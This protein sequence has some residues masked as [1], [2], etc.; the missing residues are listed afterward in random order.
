MDTEKRAAR[1]SV[2]AVSEAL[3]VPDTVVVAGTDGGSVAG[4]KERNNSCCGGEFHDT[5]RFRGVEMCVLAKRDLGLRA[6]GEPEREK[7]G[8]QAESLRC[9][10]RAGHHGQ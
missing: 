9:E 10:V 4:E 7:F 3:D 8:S 6:L 5:G 2:D 1:T